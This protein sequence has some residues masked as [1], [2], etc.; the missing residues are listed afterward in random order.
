[1]SATQ[2]KTALA[3]QSTAFNTTTAKEHFINPEC[4]GDDVARWLISKLLASGY[5]TEEEPG[6]EDFGWYIR[7]EVQGVKH[8][9]VIGY[10]PDSPD[11]VGEWLCWIE[12]S[13]GL[14]GTAFGKRKQVMPEAVETIRR[15]LSDAPEIFAVRVCK[16]NEVS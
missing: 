5:A 15:I 10:R 11:G 3:F 13:A 8:D 1:M 7:F 16:E 14:I 12:R 2:Q 6:Q 9:A 4:Y